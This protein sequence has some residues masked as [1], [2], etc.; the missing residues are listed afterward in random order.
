M[1]EKINNNNNINKNKFFFCVYW[2]KGCQQV[3]S[4]YNMIFIL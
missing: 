2:C 4:R 1:V 3:Q